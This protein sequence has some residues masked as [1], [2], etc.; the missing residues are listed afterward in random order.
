MSTLPITDLA[1][2]LPF[3]RGKRT[4]Q[5]LLDLPDGTKAVLAALDG[6]AEVAP[7]TVPYPAGVLVLAGAIEVMLGSNWQ[8]A[9]PGQYVP[10]PAGTLHAVRASAPSHCLVVHAKSLGA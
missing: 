6:G 5:V 2:F 1:T 3:E 4:N 10:I 7:H 8:P 9:R